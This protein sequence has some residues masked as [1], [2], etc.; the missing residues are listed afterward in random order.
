MPPQKRAAS[1]DSRAKPSVAPKKAKAAGPKA[2]G[3]AKPAAKPQVGLCKCALCGDMS[4]VGDRDQD[5]HQEKRMK[6]PQKS[7]KVLVWLNSHVCL[8]L[9]I[10]EGMVV[11]V[12]GKAL[13]VW[14]GR[15]V[16]GYVLRLSNGPSIM[17]LPMASRPM[18]TNA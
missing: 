5:L 15:I 4:E 11:F 1:V 17:S 18:V 12:L 2:Q 9:N 3:K 13:W 14:G 10:P 8:H 6:Q 16:L 7:G